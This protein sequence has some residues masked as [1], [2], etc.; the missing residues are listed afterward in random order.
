MAYSQ[1]NVNAPILL[2]A[3]VQEGDSLLAPTL[4]NV[5]LKCT[6]EKLSETALWHLGETALALCETLGW[7]AMDDG[8]VRYVR[9]YYPM[10]LIGDLWLCII[11]DLQ[12]CLEQSAYFL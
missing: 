11:T 7:H 1:G 9:A 12:R 10:Q 8:V 4:C 3:G 5:V 2:K 6:K